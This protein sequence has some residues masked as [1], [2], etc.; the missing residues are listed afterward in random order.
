MPFDIGRATALN[1]RLGRRLGWLPHAQAICEQLL[2]IAPCE[3]TS[4]AFAR[5]VYAWQQDRVRL[6][7]D[8]IIGSATWRR[9]ARRLHNTRTPVQAPAAGSG[10]ADLVCRNAFIFAPRHDTPGKHDATGAFHI[11]ARDFRRVHQTA[12]PLIFDNHATPE[13]RREEIFAALRAAPGGLTAIAYF[14]HGLPDG[15]SSAGI[16][17]RHIDEFAGI[18]RSKAS[19]ACRVMFYACSAGA[20][21]GFA[22]KLA[23]KL[24]GYQS[25]TGPKIE[26]YSHTNSGHSFYNPNV[27]CFPESMYVVPPYTRLFGRWRHALRNSDLWARFPFMEDEA[28][29]AEIDGT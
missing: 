20:F 12:E 26:V 24:C 23:G 22:E 2:G 19:P 13:D 14:G 9:M 28:I 25:T 27:T 10:A 15:L 5:G 1:A 7:D 17:T 4:A 8:G 18:I 16:R 21:G 11:G 6:A 29:Q 3:G